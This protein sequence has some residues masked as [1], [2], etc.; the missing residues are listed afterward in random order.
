MRLRDLTVSREVAAII[1]CLVYGAVSA[2]SV[3]SQ[4]EPVHA[5]SAP[6]AIAAAICRPVTM[7]PA[8]STGT[9][10]I[11]LIASMTSGTSTIVVT[12]PQC[13]PASVPAATRMSTPALTCLIACSRAPTRAA[14]GTPAALAPRRS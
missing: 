1:F 11:G 10:L 2:S 12:S 6:S 8:A 9:F 14:I 7:P 4:T 5:P 3:V 13:P